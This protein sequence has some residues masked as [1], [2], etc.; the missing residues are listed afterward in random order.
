MSAIEKYIRLNE[1]LGGYGELVPLDLL[2]NKEFLKKAIKQYR[3]KSLYWW[4]KEAKEFADAHGGSMANYDG[5]AYVDRLTFDFDSKE[6][7]QLARVDIDSLFTRLKELNLD[8]TKCCNIDFSGSKGFHVEILLDKDISNE[9]LKPICI[10]LANHLATFDT[11]IYD[12]TR[13]FRLRGSVHEKTG[14]YKIPLTIDEFYTLSIDEI[15]ELAKKPREL[16][17]NPE[18]VSYDLISS[19]KP[20]K[21]ESVVVEDDFLSENIKG[22]SS[23]NF[24]M[25]PPYEPKCVHAMLKGVMIT[26]QGKR[27]EIF[28]SLVNYL[29]NQNKN[30]HQIIDEL[31]TAAEL[32]HELNPSEGKFTVEE[33][34]TKVNWV[35]DNPRLSI[36]P[37]ASGISSKN[38]V[39]RQHCEAFGTVNQCKLHNKAAEAPKVVSISSVSNDF[40]QFAEDFEKNSVKTGLGIIDDNMKIVT[41]TTNLIIG[42]PGS[43][44]TSLAL[45]MM[46]KANA[47]N[48]STMFF[49]MD[50]YKN[51]VFLKIAQKL[52]DY[53]QDQILEF[54]KTRDNEKINEI[55]DLTDKYYGKSYFDFSKTLSLEDMGRRVQETSEQNNEQVKLVIVDYASRILGPY[56]DKHA[57]ATFNALKSV[58]IAETTNA[59]WI[60]LAQVSRAVGDGSTPLR[61]KRVAKESGD[62]EETATNVITVWRPF[63][64]A[65]DKDTVMRVF[66]AKNRMGPELERPLH[67][68]GTKGAVWDMDAATY[69]DYKVNKEPLELEMQ[70]TKK[71]PGFF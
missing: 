4:P 48:F 50:M 54:F 64:G 19:I 44:K 28:L 21:Q 53:S 68:D 55:R 36:I 46:L 29:R 47:N 59:A 6:N 52:T 51:L 41:N 42:A 40:A 37:G 65:A 57:N 27:N 30:K 61:S 62:W 49:S 69:D 70:K 15:K 3:Y 26:G 71:S 58:E 67:W 38:D 20:V 31:K 43:G 24:K 13:K 39:I 9:D 63:M 32:N 22:L 45:D 7:L 2:S 56:S 18:R 34:K 60:F 16:D 11:V 25:C 17:F 8:A 1:S 14:L 66:L 10:T 23:V 12:K 5:E 33:I 35:F